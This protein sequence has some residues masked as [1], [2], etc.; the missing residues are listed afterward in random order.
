MPAQKQTSGQLRPGASPG[1]K[2]GS[3]S[4][5]PNTGTSST[6]AR[7]GSSP[8]GAK[9]GSSSTGAKSG[10]SSAVAKP[11]S[12]STGTNAGSSAAQR[13]ISTQLPIRGNPRGSGNTGGPSS[14]S[15]PVLIG[16]LR[17][18]CDKRWGLDVSYN[19]AELSDCVMIPKADPRFKLLA[20]CIHLGLKFLE[21]EVGNAALV[22]TASQIILERRIFKKSEDPDTR[23]RGANVYDSGDTER[24]LSEM[25]HWVNDF[26]KKV[27]ADFP[28]TYATRTLPPSIDGMT[29]NCAWGTDIKK[30]EP[31]L[32]GRLYVHQCVSPPEI[33]DDELI[34][35]R[36]LIP[37]EQ[38]VD[39]AVSIANAIHK[40]DEKLEACK[41][42]VNNEKNAKEK[43]RLQ[44]VHNAVARD[45]AMMKTSYDT[46]VYHLS[47]TFSH[48]LCHLFTGFLTGA[49]RPRTPEKV[50]AA[51]FATPGYCG[52]HGWAWEYKVFNGCTFF[53]IESRM[54]KLPLEQ[55]TGT[56]YAHDNDSE[57]K[58]YYRYKPDFLSKMIRLGHYSDRLVSNVLTIFTNDW[59]L[60]LTSCLVGSK[61]RFEAFDSQDPLQR[62]GVPVK[63]LSDVRRKIMEAGFIKVGKV[64]PENMPTRRIPAV[65]R[66]VL[67]HL[68]TFLSSM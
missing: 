22:A 18:F 8:A 13:P 27:R 12:S 35:R 60:D 33:R 9:P 4:S 26:L 15:D 19:G 38:M 16:N 47:I 53:F 57:M 54:E 65:Q 67:M 43:A 7:P 3:S 2:T 6:G 5:G 49:N 64:F 39:Q 56:P 20:H 1:A 17:L 59:S 25:K 24:P 61:K 11:G 30:Y 23:E 68:N 66:S 37:H 44:E 34:R 55:Q 32:G 52:E 21:H 58:S 42:K 29:H 51:D 46:A 14:G 10:G 31:K 28:T 36:E 41:K 45:L 48:E 62:S 40:L 50:T 63:E